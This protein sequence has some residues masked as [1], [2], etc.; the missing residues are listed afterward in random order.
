MIMN[1][2]KE[3][4]ESILKELKDELLVENTHECPKL[5]KIV[6][7]MGTGTRNSD[8]T[9]LEALTRDLALITGQK[10]AICKARLSVSSFNK[11]RKGQIIGLKTTLRREKM[12]DF[13][14]RFIHIASPQIR[15]FRGFKTKGDKQGSYTLGLDNQNMFL[16]VDDDKVNTVQG[17]YITFVTNVRKDRKVK[18]KVVSAEQACITLLTKL[19]LP[20]KKRIRKYVKIIHRFTQ[21]NTKWN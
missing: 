4:Y 16:E 6:V 1:M 12:W 8:K 14:G 18:D 9:T 5:E 21:Q 19:G 20:F 13:L 11:L 3:K 17:M 15:D 2:M 10:P 7:T